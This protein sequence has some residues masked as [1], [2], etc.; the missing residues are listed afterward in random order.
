MMRWLKRAVAILVIAAIVTIL[1][2]WLLLHASL[3][4]LDGDVLASV[5]SEVRIERDAQGTVS[6]HAASRD[7]ASYALG[8][9]HAQERYFEMDLLRRR[10]A[11]ELAA[12]FGNAALEIDKSARAHRFRARS[13]DYL[14]ALTDQHRGTLQRYVDGVNAGLEALSARPFAYALLRQSPEPWR[15]EDSLLAAMAMFFNLQDASNSRELKLERMQHAL[16]PAV[17][18]W[19]TQPG[20]RWDAPIR[21]DRLPAAALPSPSDLDLSSTEV[22]LPPGDAMPASEGIGSNNFA[23]VGALTT[24]GG[25]LLANDMHLGLRVPNI[26]FR[27]QLHIDGRRVVGVTLPGTPAVVVGSNGDV[28]WG[29]TN[30]YGDWLDFVPVVLG[31]AQLFRETILVRGEDPVTI[32]IRVTRN[33][34][35][36]EIASDGSPLAL[37]WT[38]HSPEAVNMHL[39]DI[40]NARDVESAIRTFNAAGMPVQNALIA[41]RFGTIAWTPAGRLPKRD[42]DPHTFLETAPSLTSPAFSRLWSANARVVD[43]EA[44]VAIG[45]GGYTIGARAAQIRDGLMAKSLFAESDLLA[46]Q[47][48]DRALFL[49]HWRVRLLSVLNNN[50]D[51]FANL[52]QALN[53]WDGR[54]NPTSR[55]YRVVRAFRLRVHKLFLAQFEAPLRALD[56]QWSWPSLPHL[57]SAVEQALEEQPRHLL[58]RNFAS[59]G[60][61]LRTAAHDVELDQR[62]R[63][64]RGQA[65]WGD[66]NATQIRHPLSGA[67]PGL[68]WL[69]DMPSQTLP[70]DQYMPRVQ[71]PAF[72]ASQ[73]LVVSPGREDQAIFH[74]PGGQSGHPLSPFYGAGHED[75]STGRASPLLAGPTRHTLRLRPR[76]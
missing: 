38:A 21:G 46:I 40:E 13:S 76:G 7:D 56:K 51:D 62:I 11:G 67:L 45:D 43:G 18:A 52:R 53:D 14:A 16:P 73:R 5:D 68:A 4:A 1:G 74:M 59:W 17:F 44:L 20:S 24:H 36:T 55:A 47:L 28:A 58:A 32:D 66:Q 12:L 72:G 65:T 33:G 54:A 10:A 61:L 6:I 30:S 41:D 75:W 25:A 26:W 42:S 49:N 35:V 23:V 60:E 3:P 71:G 63:E 64:A 34:P 2:A 22:R 48:D 37:R 50:P 69:L 9:V 19:L 39:I 31:D 8:Y 70:G 27:A 15:I 57:E 29:F